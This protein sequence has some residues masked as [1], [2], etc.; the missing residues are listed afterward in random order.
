LAGVKFR[1]QYPIGS[2]ILDF[3]SPEYRLA[4][5]ADG[6]QHY[7]EPIK[8][9]DEVRTKELSRLGVEILRFNDHEILNNIEGLFEL[10]QR[11][12]EKKKGSSPHLN[13]LPDGER[14]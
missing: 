1:R 2:Y 10:V 8:R 12:L 3:Y 5:E 11:T 7:G 6:G 14:R 13:P 9:E 4:I